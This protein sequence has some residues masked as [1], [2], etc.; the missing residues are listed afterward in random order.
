MNT[1]NTDNKQL[2]IHVFQRKGLGEAPYRFKGSRRE[3]YQAVPGDSNSPVQP[4]GRCDF[5]DTALKTAFYFQ[6]ADGQ[7]FKVGSSCYYKAFKEAKHD[8]Q[9][10]VT[11]E[12]KKQRKQKNQE[13]KQRR[14]RE[15]AEMLEN[16]DMRR[17]LSS[18][19]HPRGRKGTY[20]DY[21]TW[22]SGLRAGD[23]ARNKLY[24]ELKKI[25]GE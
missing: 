4:G 16:E 5:C 22:I 10:P 20:L 23:Q 19:A 15:I 1:N 17:K 8:P 12:L 25:Q 6:S 2:K 3:I 11:R 7:T 18:L 13:L 9:D 24:K 14:R 21:A